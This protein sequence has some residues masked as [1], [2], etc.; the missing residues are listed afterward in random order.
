[1]AG[2]THPRNKV[3]KDE[4]GVML[5]MRTIR[6]RRKGVHVGEES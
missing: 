3:E 6:M 5:E 1:M 4:G 2:L